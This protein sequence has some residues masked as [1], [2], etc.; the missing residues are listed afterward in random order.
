VKQIPLMFIL[1]SARRKRDY[2]AVLRA[3]MKLLPSPVVVRTVISDF[4]LALW[5]SVHAILLSTVQHR[6][7]AFHWAQAVWRQLSKLELSTAYR[8]RDTVH[9]FCRGIMSYPFLPAA[10][11]LSAFETLRSRATN[12]ELVKL[13]SYMDRQCITQSGQ[14]KHGL[15]TAEQSGPTMT[16]RVGMQGSIE[17][18]KLVIWRSTN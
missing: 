18:P 14:P 16:A 2:R 7:C 6:G 1:M 12:D 10:D 11:I 8:Q 5:S 9:R 17:R 3:V 13:V 15:Y 4:E